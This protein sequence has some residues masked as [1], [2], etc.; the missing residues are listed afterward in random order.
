LLDEAIKTAIANGYL[1]LRLIPLFL[2]PGSHID[3][4]IPAIVEN[5]RQT[6]PGIDIKL[7]SCLVQNRQFIEFVAAE[8]A[9]D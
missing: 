2:L 7:G 4:D 8:I 5:F 1:S 6:N 9:E 3:E